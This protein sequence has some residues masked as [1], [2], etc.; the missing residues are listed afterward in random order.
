MIITTFSYARNHGQRPSGGPGRP[1]MVILAMV[2]VSLLWAPCAFAAPDESE[3]QIIARML[4]FLNKPL[5]GT[6]R[7]GLVYGQEN[8]RSFDE[9]SSLRHLMGG[10]FKSGNVTLQPV[11]LSLKDAGR[12]NVDLLILMDEVSRTAPAQSVLTNVRK[13][14]CV[15]LDLEQVK[16]GS[17]AIGIETSP[18][19]EILVNRAVAVRN[20]IGFAGAFRMLITEY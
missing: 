2:F 10:G 6:V 5:T 8:S 1:P 13:L 20:E 7:V 3:L 16:N 12:A 15:T 18:R 14:P 19:T 9:A 4:S 17:C 11:P